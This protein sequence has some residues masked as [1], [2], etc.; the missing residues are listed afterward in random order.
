MP[1]VCVSCGGSCGEKAGYICRNCAAVIA[2]YGGM[3]ITAKDKIGAANL[4]Y[5]FPYHSWMGVDLGRAVRIMKYEGHWKLGGELANLATHIFRKHPV[6]FKA[7]IITAIP[8]HSSRIRERGF[9]QSDLIGMSLSK[10][11]GIEFLPLLKRAKNTLQQAELSAIDRELNVKDVFCMADGYN[12]DNKG[13]IL[14]D[15]QIT[16]GSTLNSAGEVLI[17]SG[18][19]WVVGLSITH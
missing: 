18:A 5:V 2:Q 17:K 10:E 15:D 6:L 1:G 16:T 13:I 9:N 3:K 8:L 12:I 14:V 4:Y 11:T 7:D 19:G